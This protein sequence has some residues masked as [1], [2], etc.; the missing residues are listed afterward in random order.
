MRTMAAQCFFLALAAMLLTVAV[1]EGRSKYDGRMLT[2]S[3]TAPPGPSNN[4]FTITNPTGADATTTTTLFNAL[5]TPRGG[6][7]TCA[8]NTLILARGLTC[9]YNYKI[10][11]ASGFTCIFD[12]SQVTYTDCLSIHGGANVVLVGVTFDGKSV[13]R[14][15]P[16]V[17][18]GGSTTATT[19][20]TVVVTGSN[21]PAG[22]ALEVD[23]PT[24]GSKAKVGATVQL[25][26]STSFSGNTADI[27]VFGATGV[28]ATVTSCYSAGGS[29]GNTP[30][31]GYSGSTAV[32][33]CSSTAV[34]P[35]ST[36][37]QVNNTAST[38]VPSPVVKVAPTCSACP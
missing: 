31:I 25:T 30:G 7:I 17:A 23:G 11:C 6:T 26:G 8:F 24:P 36:P 13:A 35:T 5:R 20:S 38:P 2:I 14:T 16:L 4:A 1:V 3:G 29:N 28:K 9:N 22:P 33:V 37:T 12:C 21:Y 27:T 18:I 32:T 19:L 10:Q 15:A 34:S